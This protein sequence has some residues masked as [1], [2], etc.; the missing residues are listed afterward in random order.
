MKIPY[1]VLNGLTWLF[2]EI[3]WLVW[4]IAHKNKIRR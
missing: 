4:K 1:P 3:E 2:N